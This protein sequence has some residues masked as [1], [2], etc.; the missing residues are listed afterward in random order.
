MRE[1]R[2]SASENQFDRI[3]LIPLNPLEFGEVRFQ[4]PIRRASEL[5]TNG[6]IAA[7]REETAHS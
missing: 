4:S 1:A 7:L 5:A 6:A 2:R 3:V